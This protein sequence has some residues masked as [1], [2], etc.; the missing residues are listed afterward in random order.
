MEENTNEEKNEN[1]DNIEITN[2][3]K[4]KINEVSEKEDKNEEKT[5]KKDPLELE[6]NEEGIYKEDINNIVDYLTNL[7]FDKYSRDM[8]IKEALMVLKT[9]MDKDHEL[10]EKSDKIQTLIN[11][12]EPM[13]INMNINKIENLNYNNENIKN[14]EQKVVSEKIQRSELLANQQGTSSMNNI[15][16]NFDKKLTNI[17]VYTKEK[18]IDLIAQIEN[19]RQLFV[20]TNK[21]Q[22]FTVNPLFKFPTYGNSNTNTNIVNQ[23]SKMKEAHIVEIGG[24]ALHP[25]S[26]SPL[27]YLTISINL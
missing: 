20:N 15:I 18:I 25:P 4:E 2:E 26:L 9:K 16:Y 13:N 24:K 1:I 21:L 22:S 10:K 5:E 19:L 11:K 27:K 7:D 3:N 23:P 12:I 17:E 14:E 6:E 8:E